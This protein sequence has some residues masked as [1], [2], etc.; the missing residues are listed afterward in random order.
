MSTLTQRILEYIAECAD[1][2]APAASASA[3]VLAA[4]AAKFT[5]AVWLEQAALDVQR[6]NIKF[7]THA[8]KF[9]HGDS[10]TTSVLDRQVATA[11]FEVLS[12]LN[13]VREL[14]ITGNAAGQASALV[15]MLRT[16]DNEPT[17]IESLAQGDTSALAPLAKDEEQLSRW[18]SGFLAV[19]QPQP[20]TS[21]KY[22]KEV[23]FPVGD[24]YHLLAPIFPTSLYHTLHNRM[25]QM[26][27]PE[28]F[29]DAN[30][31]RSAGK[32]HPLPVIRFPRVAGFEVCASKPM[33]R[34]YLNSKRGGLVNLLPCM[35][36]VW[37]TQARTV[38]SYESI[39]QHR[40]FA[41]SVYD[42]VNELRGFLLSTGDYNNVHIRRGV[43]RR[44]SK[45]VDALI[46]YVASVYTSS[47]SEN[48]PEDLAAGFGRWLSRSLRG[49]KA[50]LNMQKTEANFFSRICEP[51]LVAFQEVMA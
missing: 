12:S 30:A 14:D 45:I 40:R 8:P 4:H 24:D 46:S 2:K 41:R 50:G 23:F 27:F 35:P 44:V 9:V 39:L 15:L 5:P 7:V 42:A 20:P 33:T 47:W 34:S 3:D 22:G 6:F 28:G 10:R 38:D 26:R 37:N 32:Y 36:P 25:M 29:R 48:W 43:I 18:A 21:H 49:K 17:L 16:A 31:A 51:E 1:K 19:F 13:A 11:P